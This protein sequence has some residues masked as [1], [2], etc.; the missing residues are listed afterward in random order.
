MRLLRARGT[1]WRRKFT[2][3]KLCIQIPLPEDGASFTKNVKDEERQADSDDDDS[4]AY[5]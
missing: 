5:A 2:Y 1:V 4:E 3:I